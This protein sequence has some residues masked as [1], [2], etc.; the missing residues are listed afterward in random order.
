M[1]LNKSVQNC[2]E[3]YATFRGRAPRSEYWWFLLFQSLCILASA[4][5]D[6]EIFILVVAGAFVIP[7]ISVTV[8]RLH[9]IGRSGWWY[10]IQL[11]PLIGVIIMLVWTCTKGSETD[12]EYGSPV[13]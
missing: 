9:D 5:L 13:S 12:N 4:F 1:T 6:G 8:R 3:K 10:W 11:L 2:I 7:T